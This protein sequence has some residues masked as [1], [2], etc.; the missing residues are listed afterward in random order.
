MWPS[1]SKKN[2]E[3]KQQAE[4]ENIPPTKKP[5]VDKKASVTERRVGGPG[6]PAY[7]VKTRKEHSVKESQDVIK[8]DL[9]KC[10]LKSVDDMP[11]PEFTINGQDIFSDDIETLKSDH[12]WFGEK[13]INTGQR[14]L[15]E[16]FLGTA[17]LYLSLIHI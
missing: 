4:K 6:D 16:I 7:L 3:R 9:D 2:R 13:L 11:S 8:I 5:C 10:Q 1:K 14:M 12:K 17:G 15:P